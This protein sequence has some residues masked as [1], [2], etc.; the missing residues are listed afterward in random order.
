MKKRTI[1]IIIGFSLGIGLTGLGKPSYTTHALP[2]TENLTVKSISQ[3]FFDK[4]NKEDYVTETE[5]G[6]R[7]Q[8]AMDVESQILSILEDKALEEEKR[9]KFIENFG[10]NPEFRG[11]LPKRALQEAMT[12]I[13]KPYY[14]GAEGK[15]DYD[16]DGDTRDG[17]DCSG[18]LVWAYYRQG[19]TDLPRTTKGQWTQGERILKKDIQIGDLIYFLNDRRN[20]PVDHVGIYIGEGKMLH[21]PRPGKNV[22]TREVPWGNMKTIRRHNN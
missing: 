12:Q 13:G 11:T 21:A 18:L 6:Q 16:G 3:A 1:G 19:K 14:W 10:G 9:V 5:T 4:K 22:E 15:E 20:G 17:Y 8:N 2:E 7:I